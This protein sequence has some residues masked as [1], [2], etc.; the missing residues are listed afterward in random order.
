MVI[1]GFYDLSKIR[2]ESN[3]PH[4]SQRCVNTILRTSK[5]TNARVQREH[6]LIAHFHTL[7]SDGHLRIKRESGAD[8]LPLH[9]SSSSVYRR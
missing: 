9:V 8:W 4:P 7:V 5:M 6:R 1:L 2:S 3:T